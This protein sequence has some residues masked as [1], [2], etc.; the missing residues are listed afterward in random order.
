M[1]KLRATP[2][3]AMRLILPKILRH[4]NSDQGRTP[5]CWVL[6]PSLALGLP[7]WLA[8]RA[9]VGRTVHERVPAD[10]RAAPAA[11]LSGAAIGLQGPPEV[12]ALPVHVDVEAVKGRA[13]GL[14]RLHQ[15]AGHGR[16]E[17]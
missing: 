4:S 10:R 7:A 12:P 14:E 2:V 5:R 1:V 15:D 17:A 3:P 6:H 13:A 16:E 8:L 9:T 11:G